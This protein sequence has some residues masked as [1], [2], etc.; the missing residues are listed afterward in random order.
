M[1]LIIATYNVNGIADPTKSR[2][3]FEFLGTVQGEVIVIQETHGEVGTEH[4]WQKE[5]TKGQA[6]FHS[7]IKKQAE[8]GVAILV[9]SKNIYM[10]KLTSNF[11]VEF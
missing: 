5:W 10:E 7:S 2:A 11:K 1:E 8:S 9:Q 3:V 6:F 4:R